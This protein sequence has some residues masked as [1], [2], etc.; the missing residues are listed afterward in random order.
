MPSPT[1]TQLINGNFQDSEGNLLAN[2]YLTFR[3]SQDATVSGSSICAGIEIT[4]NLNSTGNVSTSPPQSVWGTDVMSPVNCYYTVTGYTQKGQPVW[5]PNNQQVISGS[6]FDLDTWIPNQVFSWQPPL[7]TVTLETNSTLNAN[8]F[9]LNLVAGS[10]V[11][12]VN[13]GGN[14]TISSTAQS[15]LLQTNSSNNATQ[16]QL[17]LVAGTGVSLVNSGGTV[18]ISASGGGFSTSGQGFFFG[19]KSVGPITGGSGGAFNNRI[20]TDVYVIPIELEN[21][22]TIRKVTVP[23]QGSLGS[24]S[25]NIYIAIFDA[26]G[27][28]RL[29][30]TG[31][32]PVPF[33]SSPT[34][35]Q[36]TLGSPVALSAGYY[37]LAWGQDGSS[38]ITTVTTVDTSALQTTWNQ[39]FI[40]VGYIASGISA[41]NMITTLTSLTDRSLNVPTIMF[42]V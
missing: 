18:T 20:I 14:V 6:T 29:L 31:A 8:Q 17:N 23:V 3:L 11:T 39:S 40:R 28:T 37:Q 1:P 13:S 10:G 42:E 34:V 38:S 33:N 5:G 19:A 41:G 35:Y 2:G 27:T 32:I 22:Y 9:L 25:T 15:V 21:A 16:S 24:S 12:L 26:A 30:Y 36:V 7:Q 4:I